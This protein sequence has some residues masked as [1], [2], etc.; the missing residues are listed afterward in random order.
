MWVQILGAWREAGLVHCDLKPDNVAV[1][2]GDAVYLLDVESAC[3]LKNKTVRV[4]LRVLRE[5]LSVSPDPAYCV[6]VRRRAR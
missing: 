4:C 1:G 6:C 3:F 2:D 5:P